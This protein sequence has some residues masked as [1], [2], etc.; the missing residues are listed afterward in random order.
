MVKI[1][2]TDGRVLLYEDAENIS[3][4]EEYESKAW[5][6]K[7]RFRESHAKATDVLADADGTR[8][9]LVKSTG[10]AMGWRDTEIVEVVSAV[11]FGDFTM[12]RELASVERARR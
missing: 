10:P 6:G 5:G 12:D 11:R 1:V 4:L 8:L 2:L 3:V 9:V 7:L